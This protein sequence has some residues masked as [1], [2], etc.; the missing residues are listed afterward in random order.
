MLFCYSERAHVSNDGS[1]ALVYIGNLLGQ[2]LE[3]R[4]AFPYPRRIPYTAL[5][6]DDV[7]LSMLATFLG[8]Q[9]F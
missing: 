4:I 5:A 1:T 6:V 2:F 9:T 3:I 8:L 7:K